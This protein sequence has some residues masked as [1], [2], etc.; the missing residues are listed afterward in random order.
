[1]NQSRRLAAIAQPR[2]RASPAGLTA[3][4]EARTSS[5]PPGEEAPKLVV[6]D[7]RQ[8]ILRNLGQPPDFICQVSNLRLKENDPA[9]RAQLLHFPYNRLGKEHRNPELN[10]LVLNCGFPVDSKFQRDAEA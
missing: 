2:L 1:M 6:L 7:W 5:Q 9:G 3:S 8:A 10:A 4:P